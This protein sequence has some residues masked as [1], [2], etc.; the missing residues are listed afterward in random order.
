MTNQR[1]IHRWLYAFARDVD[2]TRLDDHVLSHGN[3]LRRVFLYG[4]AACLENEEARREFGSRKHGKTNRNARRKYN[5]V[6][7]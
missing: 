4:Y 5:E 2:K 6:Q 7:M 3:H 1:I